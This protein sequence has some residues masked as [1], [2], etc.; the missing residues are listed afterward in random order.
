MVKNDED[1]PF[2]DGHCP[3]NIDWNHVYKKVRII[4]N[5]AC[6]ALLGNCVFCTLLGTGALQSYSDPTINNL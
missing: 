3:S 5:I 6:T 1:Y 2:I 4:I